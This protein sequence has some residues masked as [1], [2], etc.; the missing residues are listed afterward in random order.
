MSVSYC[1]LENHPNWDADQTRH[2]FLFICL[3]I[4]LGCHCFKLLIY[5][6]T[7]ANLS[8]PWLHSFHAVG[9]A[10]VCFKC[11]LFFWNYQV[12]Q[13]VFRIEAECKKESPAHFKPLLASHLL[14]SQETKV[15]YKPK[16]EEK[17]KNTPHVEISRNLKSILMYFITHNNQLLWISLK[18]FH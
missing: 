9:S 16:D 13:H 2:L 14:L 11:L 18:R 12:T 7:S 17:G 8:W 5:W 10:E 3:S 1:S 6:S 4:Q 15:S